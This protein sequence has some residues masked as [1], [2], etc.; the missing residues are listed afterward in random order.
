MDPSGQP[1]RQSARRVV[2]LGRDPGNDI[3]VRSPSVSARHAR[4]VVDEGGPW[5]E[6]LGSRNGTFVGTP[7]RRI[8]RERIGLHDTI[9]LGDAVL[10]ENA[11]EDLLERTTP[12]EPVADAIPLAD[13]ALVTFGRGAAADV[14]L[15]RPLASALHAS[16][17]V[18]RGRVV[19]RD[20]GSSDGTFV[21]GRRIDR[22]VELAPGMVVQIADRRFRLAADARA[23]EPLEGV[24]RDVV[25]ADGV[26]V[27]AAGRRLLEGVSLVVQ[28]GELVAIM[29]P[30]G[31]GKSTLLAVLNGQT[32]PSAGRL[33][34]GGL[35]LHD[36]YDLFRGRI[37]YVPQDDILH[38]DLTVHQAL[39]YAARL[40]LPRD[41]TDAEIETRIAAVIHE[42][43][44]DGTEHTR[45]GDQRK[46]GVSGG[47]R[48]RVNLAMELLTDPPILVLDEP[49]SGLSSVDA[50]SVVELL[51][52]LADAGKTILVTIHQPSLEAFEKFD[53]VA[54]IARDESTGQTGRLAWFGRAYPDAIT[55]FEPRPSGTP[56]PASVDGLLRGLATRPVA[57]WARAWEQSVAKSIWVDRRRTT[58]AAAL[59]PRRRSRPRTAA[60]FTQWLTLVRR[61]LAVKAADGWG[62]AVLFAQAPVVGLLIAAVFAKVVRSPPTPELWPKIGVNMATTLFVTALAAIWFGCSS[63]AREIVT[64]WPIYRRERMVGLSI[65]AYVL[66]K[67]TV[68]LGIA[69]VQSLLLLAIV[70]PAC[71]L[72][73]PWLGIFAVVYAAAL[74]GGGLGLLISA[75]LRTTEAAAGIL[76]VLLL[77]MI[78]LGGILVPLADLPV[79]T[80]PIAALMRSRWA[81]EGLVVPEADRRPRL[82]IGGPA[83]E[84]SGDAGADAADAPAEDAAAAAPAG[85]PAPAPSADDSTAARRNPFRLASDGGSHQ[86]IL[87][88]RRKIAEKLE[89]AAGRAKQELEKAKT[90]MEE[91]A[92][93]MEAE[94][95]AEAERKLDAAKAEFERK[96]AESAERM[97]KEIEARVATAREDAQKESAAAAGRMREE[98]EKRVEEAREQGRKESDAARAQVRAEVEAKVAEARESAKQES[99][100]AGVT[101][102]ADIEKRMKEIEADFERRS[103][104]ATT[105]IEKKLAEIQARIDAE[106][107]KMNAAL[108]SL[109]A[110]TRRTLVPAVTAAAPSKAATGGGG[111]ADSG[112]GRAAGPD[113]QIHAE[114]GRGPSSDATRDTP[115]ADVPAREPSAVEPP[116][117]EAP[118]GEAPARA[119]PSGVDAA[120]AVAPGAAPAAD[121]AD[122]PAADGREEVS[123]RIPPAGSAAA[124]PANAPV[125]VPVDMAERFF[126]SGGW[127][128]PRAAPLAVLLGMFAA[129][130]AG[131]A[132]AQ[133]RRDANGR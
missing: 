2:L 81:F 12:R 64:E 108:E 79:V 31:A 56:A 63:T 76:P 30:S 55:F 116:G 65:G 130:V 75:T 121:A 133:S 36:H 16:V 26:A 71:R 7:P 4:V 107:R 98:M 8:E 35:D 84:E 60:P 20:L 67:V 25:E 85:T 52:K 19:V 38:A 14:P 109:R 66:S 22:P 72:D 129:G 73:S 11:L 92:R 111:D 131:T 15:D 110:A 61:T 112:G 87:P 62:T 46:R 122:G 74:A 57:D 13:A 96:S 58:S 45:V 119:V 27:E 104:E 89:E 42:L 59:P 68:L 123:A 6:D 78:V 39:W 18:D 88:G 77:P 47:Q 118:V 43:G 120:P 51:R 82:Q 54:V 70:A 103:H 106:R 21:D 9:T 126:G 99:D 113:D 105:G 40:R 49:T 97:K 90:T 34:V 117:G 10:P 93:Q 91:K 83:P 100:A 127:R 132:V 86:F 115:S 23:L 5:L 1:P 102:R 124:A 32:V 48:K 95:K 17:T 69:A 41:T 128:S 125:S 29:G 50:L 24:E 53:A 80:R 44:L 33:I 28:P 37:G 3:V 114:S 94:M 101:A